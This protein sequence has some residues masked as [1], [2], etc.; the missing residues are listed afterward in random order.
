MRCQ[1]HLEGGVC[2]RILM[3]EQEFLYL[4]LAVIWTW[5][6]IV[7]KRIFH[8]QVI[9]VKLGVSRT[10]RVAWRIPVDGICNHRAR[11][12]VVSL[13]LASLT[14]SAV[15][16][17]LLPQHGAWYFPTYHLLSRDSGP[18]GHTKL[19]TSFRN[20]LT[21]TRICTQVCKFLE[22][23][24]KD[25]MCSLL[26]LT[27]LSDGL[28]G[29][30]LSLCHS[31]SPS[32]HLPPQPLPLSIS[33]VLP[34][35]SSPAFLPWLACIVFASLCPVDFCLSRVRVSKFLFCDD[36]DRKYCRLVCCTVSVATTDLC[37]CSTK[38]G[39]DNTSESGGFCVPIKLY[40][41]N[42]V[43]ALLT[44]QTVVCWLFSE[45]GGWQ[46]WLRK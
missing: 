8:S 23:I 13:H 28:V 40:L 41:Q 24:S 29:Q 39:K 32:V 19:N 30:H 26:R 2:E 9:K 21:H 16:L 44:L 1:K 33:L 5:S 37:C 11:E 18:S 45:R 31:S 17:S 43:V 6:K 15:C 25:G 4:T 12:A 35:L 34:S 14:F 20:C 36:P 46:M 27:S 38:T 3:K 42:Q 10:L 7:S 22:M